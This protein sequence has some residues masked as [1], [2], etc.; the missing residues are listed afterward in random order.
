M[1]YVVGRRGGRFEIRESFHT[2][3]GPRSRTLVGFNVLSDDIL[4]AAARRAQRSFDAEAVIHS[5]RRAGARVQVVTSG[6]S[7]ARD[8]FLSGSRT[9]ARTVGQPPPGNGGVDAGTALLELLGFADMVVAGQPPQPFEPLSF[10]ALAQL[11]KRPAEAA[12]AQRP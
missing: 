10:P 5:A 6:A 1:A 9:M 8:R 2:S 12:L 11:T 3:K 7:R 4:A